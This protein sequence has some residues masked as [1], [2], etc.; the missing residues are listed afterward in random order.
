[1][2]I[3]PGMRVRLVHAMDS[4]AVPVNTEGTIREIVYPSEQRMSA[5]NQPVVFVDFGSCGEKGFEMCL[6]PDT[7][8]PI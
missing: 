8:R 2:I 1:M 6:F 4:V 3:S 7:V 5:F